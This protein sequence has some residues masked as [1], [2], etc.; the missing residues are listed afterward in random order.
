MLFVS[1]GAPTFAI[2]P[3]LLG[4]QLRALGEQLQGLAAILVV[5]PHWQTRDIR[6]QATPQPETVHDFGGFPAALYSIE[7]PAH[8][9]PALA[10]QTLEVLRDAGLPV[11]LDSGRGLDHG[12]WVPLLHLMPGAELPVFQVSMPYTLDTAAALR[13]GQALAV[14]RTRGVLIMASGGMTHNLGEFRAHFSSPQAYALEFTQW[15]R[16][17]V[18]QND[19]ERIVDYRRLAPHAQRA[20]PSEEHFLPLLTALGAAG[21]DAVQAIDGGMTHGMLSM[22][23]YTWGL[24]A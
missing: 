12:A 22:E 1:H 13:L 5:S 14:L 15:V 16:D 10:Q 9:D 8:G 3:G 20:H 7:Y 24:P 2:E 11:T 4:P 21:G 17:A 19:L 6:V 23:S 18:L